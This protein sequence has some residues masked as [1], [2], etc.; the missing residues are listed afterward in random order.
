MFVHCVYF[1][2]KPDLDDESLEVF[3]RGLESLVK[4]PSVRFG[5]WGTPAATDRPV[6]DRSYSYG[7][8]CAF[9]DE[10]GHDEY[11][12][13]PDHDAFRETCS[14]MWEQVRIYDFR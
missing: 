2:L 9:D 1:W 4:I 6:I 12:V 14:S 3:K 8:V 10:P 11:Q 5:E 13:H 7:L